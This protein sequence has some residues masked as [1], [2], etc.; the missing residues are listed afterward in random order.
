MYYI[1]YKTARPMNSTARCWPYFVKEHQGYRLKPSQLKPAL[2]AM[3]KWASERVVLLPIT[4][5]WNRTIAR[6]IPHTLLDRARIRCSWTHT[7]G[8][9]LG[10]CQPIECVFP[11]HKWSSPEC[12]TMIGIM[13]HAELL[14][15]RDLVKKYRIDDGVRPFRD[16]FVIKIWAELWS[17]WK[18]LIF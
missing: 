18:Y 2:S 4:R 16:I 3:T 13:V 12:K 1:N 7:A 9:G 17:K 8:E 14:P 15:T 10:P 5:G 11:K 6:D